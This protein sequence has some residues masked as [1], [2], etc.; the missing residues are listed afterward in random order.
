MPRPVVIEIAHEL[1]RAEAHRRFKNGFGKIRDQ[2]GVGMVAFEERWEGE[3]LHFSAAALGQIGRR[4][5]RCYGKK[6]ENRARSAMGP[7]GLGGD[8]TKAGPKRRHVVA[9]AKIE[10]S[11]SMRHARTWVSVG[12]LGEARLFGVKLKAS[13]VPSPNSAAVSQWLL[14]RLKH[15]RP[16]SPR[17]ASSRPLPRKSN[18]HEARRMAAEPSA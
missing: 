11:R 18:Y 16:P 3:R 5:S 12:E 2:L 7:C 1:G 13:C 10:S 9:T 8:A 6:R 15:H 4:P 14:K 17:L